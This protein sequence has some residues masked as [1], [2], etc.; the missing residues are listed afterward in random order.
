MEFPNNLYSVRTAARKSQQEVADALSISQSE[1]SRMEKGR[2]TIDSY[3]TQLAKVFNVDE[4][5]IAAA[6]QGVRLAQLE[7]GHTSF[8]MPVYGTPDKSGGLSWTGGPID[9][10]ERPSGMMNNVDAYAVYMPSDVMSPR[11][12]AGE[13]L[14]VDPNLP[15]R[16]GVS[17]V[18]SI[19]NS[20]IR[21]ICEFSEKANGKVVFF[22]R[23]PAE[24]IELLIEDIEDIHVIRAASFF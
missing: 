23:N 17:A 4:R 14:F 3:Q 19:K 11:F 24:K 2:R 6:S 16:A 13:V 7:H 18:I 9:M 8:R 20:N 12:N 10:V 5:D 1:Y 21:Q 15:L 22:T